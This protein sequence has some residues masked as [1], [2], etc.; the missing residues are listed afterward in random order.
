MKKLKK[1]LL[2]SSIAIILIALSI[3]AFIKTLS[4]KVER[5]DI[6]RS[7]ITEV[8]KG[9]VPENSNEVITMALL[10]ADYSNNNGAADV[11][12]LLS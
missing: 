5:I 6:D 2:L 10:G 8:S 3:F 1:I 12:M 7:S 11:T 4:S 9:T